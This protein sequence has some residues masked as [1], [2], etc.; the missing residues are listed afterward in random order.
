MTDSIKLI[1]TIK[2]M[3]VKGLT[4]SEK[5]ELSDKKPVSHLLQKQW[6][7][8]SYAHIKD[9]IDPAEIWKNIISICWNENE[10]KKIKKQRYLRIGYSVAAACLLLILG[11]WT[12]DY[13]T[14]PAITISSPTG[15]RTIV[16]LP[17]QSKIWLSSGSTIHYKKKF[18][19]NRT[20]TLEGEATF[21]VEK[22]VS[23]FRV[24]FKNAMIEVKGTEFNI[25]S[26]AN[27]T[28]IS[29]YTGK[30]EFS[31]ELL[32]RRI[33]MHPSERLIYNSTTQELTHSHIDLKEYDWQKEEY[34]F[35]DKPISELIKFMNDSYNVK[36][37]IHN[38]K[39]ERHLFSGT[40]RKNETLENLLDKICI[41]FS[42]N[43]KEE[44]DSMIL[45]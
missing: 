40:I 25:K 30:I 19:N 12:S 41:S 45:Y 37:R 1:Q 3:L 2:K 18:L 5:V 32:N 33:E 15:T 44:K 26:V 35:V 42:L 24:H 20:I 9:Q 17:D 6:E 4:P 22:S 36:I 43:I 13:L 21:D 23:P 8:N 16:T 31:T 7:E 34:R 10:R 11:I 29:L 38:K 39:D 27:L 28:E 14:N